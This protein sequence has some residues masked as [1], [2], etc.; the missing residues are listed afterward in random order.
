[1]GIACLLG[2]SI[3]MALGDSGTPTWKLKS[4]YSRGI[5]RSFKCDL[6]QEM[7]RVPRVLVYGGSRSLRMDPATIKQKTGLVSFNFGMHNGHPEDA[8]AFTDW[9][10][11]QH[12][13]KPPAVI[14]CVQA[15]LFR[16]V[17]MNPG[18]I[19]DE[20]LS[21]AFPKSLI[22]AKMGWAMRQPKR[23]L[24]SGRRYGYDGMLWWNGYDTKRQRGLTLN[25]S[26]N[27]YLDPQMLARAG[28][29]QLPHNTRAMAYFVRTVR[30][31]NAY[32]IK[33]LIL[34]MPYHPRA[35]SAFMAVGWGAK[36]RWLERY[37]ASLQKHLDFKVLNCLHLSTFGGTPNGFYDGA[38]LTAENSRR[39]IRYCVAHAPACFKL[40][41]PPSP[42]PSPSPS[43]SPSESATP[44]QP[45]APPA[46]TPVP[47]TTAA[48]ADFLE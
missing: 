8:W 18:L 47:E 16:D 48:P 41:K 25:Q 34:I 29:G 45:V 33:P 15:S 42:T 30:L 5:D 36:E 4:Y 21:Q 22:K 31:L 43:P 1:L 11:D 24:L 26:L 44:V 38:H 12:P 6:Y 27:G 19:V 3:P 13:D 32:K 2:V 20:R 14:W 37:L 9:V 17:P 40:P 10:L 23:N 39:L 7:P 46:Y 35:L 28:N